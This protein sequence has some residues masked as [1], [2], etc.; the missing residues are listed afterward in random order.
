MGNILVWAASHCSRAGPPPP[1]SPKSP[2]P[3]VL[4][5]FY[6]GLVAAIIRPPRASYSDAALGPA[7]FTL[8]PDGPSYRRTDFPIATSRGLVLQASHWEPATAA[9]TAPRPCVVYL[10]G[11]ASCR[12]EAMQVPL[13]PRARPPW[14]HGGRSWSGPDPK[15]GGDPPPLYGPQNCCTEQCALSAPEAPEILF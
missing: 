13:P 4:G 12:A 3:G 9:P 6:D 8:G 11:N 14:R 1:P 2:L 5:Q 10:H 15:G 7:A